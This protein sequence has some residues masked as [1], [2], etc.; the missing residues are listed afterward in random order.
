MINEHSL[1]FPISRTRL[2]E[3]ARAILLMTCPRWPIPLHLAP[4]LKRDAYKASCQTPV[5]LHYSIS[6]HLCRFPIP[7]SHFPLGF[8]IFIINGLRSLFPSPKRHIICPFLMRPTTY[9]F[10]PCPL[11]HNRPCPLSLPTQT[12]RLPTTPVSANALP[13]TSTIPLLSAR[14]PILPLLSLPLRDHPPPRPC[15]ASSP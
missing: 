8:I 6:T 11:P 9:S 5:A 14:R 4:G 3:S 1:S 12:W 2:N 13:Q 10:R 7:L 15:S